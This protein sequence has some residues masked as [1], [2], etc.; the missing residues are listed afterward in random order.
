MLILNTKIFQN[1]VS[2]PENDK[3]IPWTAELGL[4]VKKVLRAYLQTFLNTLEN[5]T[6]ENRD[7]LRTSKSRKMMSDLTFK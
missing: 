2:E 1:C 6:K 7:T 3:A 5:M 4:A